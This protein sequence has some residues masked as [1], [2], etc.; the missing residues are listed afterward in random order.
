MESLNHSP[1]HA[2]RRREQQL[3]VRE[4]IEQQTR[5]HQ[6][7][8]QAHVVT[9]PTSATSAWR[10]NALRVVAA[11]SVAGSLILASKLVTPTFLDNNAPNASASIQAPD[12]VSERSPLAKSVGVKPSSK[13]AVV[14][15]VVYAD[16]MILSSAYIEK[17]KID[18]GLRLRSY[19]DNG[20]GS[21]WTIGYGHTGLMPDGRPI[22]PNMTITQ[23]QADALLVLDL[24]EHKKAVSDILGKTPVT[25]GM[26][27]ALVDFSYNKG[28]DKLAESTLLRRLMA[29]DY[30]G[31]ADEYLR[32]T[33]VTRRDAQ[34]KPIRDANGRVI[35]DELPGLV[36]RAEEK[37]DHMLSGL[38]DSVI[39][40]LSK[41][42]KHIQT[43]ARAATNSEKRLRPVPLSGVR[44]GQDASLLDKAAQAIVRHTNQI[45]NKHDAHSRMAESL[46][47]HASQLESAY[48]AQMKQAGLHI[49]VNSDDWLQIADLAN[50]ANV[51]KHVASLHKA[52]RRDDQRKIEAYL[53]QAALMRSASDLMIEARSVKEAGNQVLEALAERARAMADEFLEIANNV[54]SDANGVKPL[55]NDRSATRLANSLYNLGDA[56][57]ERLDYH[58]SK[59]S[60]PQR[61]SPA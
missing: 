32:W 22:G 49:N 20:P 41:D 19:L 6:G 17:L 42:L 2:R 44:L 55:L 10:T 61:F 23:E 4:I 34:G 1:H 37:R 12:K 15:P 26:F 30:V 35:M 31:A 40:L 3:T 52:Q 38:D 58:V 39:N 28:P 43:L 16:Q 13:P 48:K 57:E 24:E 59:E 36:R 8:P 7:H 46:E 27:E 18:E 5:F 11:I 53:D 25:Q 60:A 29:G 33:K 14:A 21:T 9:T 45:Q 50:Q 56:L 54:D 47:R 51:L